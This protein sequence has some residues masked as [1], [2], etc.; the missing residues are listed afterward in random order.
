MYYS[1][2]DVV[3]FIEENDIRFIKLAFVDIAGIQK[4]ISIM[5]SEFKRAF[6]YRYCHGDLI[7]AE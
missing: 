3:Q 7:T 6:R 2:H 4:N 1:Y 5:P